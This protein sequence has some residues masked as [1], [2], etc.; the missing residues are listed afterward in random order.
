MGQVG[1]GTPEQLD[2]PRPLAARLL[3]LVLHPVERGLGI[4]VVLIGRQPVF[5]VAGQERLHA[6]GVLPHPVELVESSW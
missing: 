5:L 2:Q 1:R 4:L 6:A 3:A